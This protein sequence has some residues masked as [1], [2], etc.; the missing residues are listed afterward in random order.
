MSSSVSLDNLALGI[1]ALSRSGGPD[2]QNVIEGYLER[3]LQGVPMAERL[4]LIES[5]AGKFYGHEPQARRDLNLEPTE[6][7]RL[8]SLF[9]GDRI[10]ASDLSS[11]EVSEKLANSLNTVFDTLNQIICVIQSTLL[12]RKTEIETIRHVI[13]S[14]LGEGGEEASLKMYLDQIQ[15]AFLTAHKAFQEAARAIVGEMLS[16]LDPDALANENNSGLKFGP[17]RKAQ[18]FESYVEKYQGCRKWFD[19]DRFMENV[20]REFEK[21]CQK[22]YQERI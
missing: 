8:L 6:T 1:R 19:S 16:A 17:L 9:L 11:S 4:T 22:T 3:E 15:H 5:L 21:K 7:A 14:Q 10:T 13:G 12:G 20:L 2:I 18:L